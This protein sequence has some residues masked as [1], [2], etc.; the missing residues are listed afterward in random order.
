MENLIPFAAPLC[1]M[2]VYLGK[3]YYR[4][5][6]HKIWEREVEIL[7]KFSIEEK[8]IFFSNRKNSIK[9][10]NNVLKEIMD[11]IKSKSLENSS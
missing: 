7:E 2:A 1:I 6:Q 9:D 5:V 11:L 10:E 3:S 8:I 4:W